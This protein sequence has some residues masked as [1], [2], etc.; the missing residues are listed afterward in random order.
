MKLHACHFSF[1]LTRTSSYLWM[2]VYPLSCSCKLLRDLSVVHVVDSEKIR[3][4][5]PFPPAVPGEQWSVPTKSAPRKG[6]RWN[7]NRVMHG[8]EHQKLDYR[9]TEE[10]ILVWHIIFFC[11]MWTAG[12]I[13]GA[14]LGKRW[15]QDAP[16]EEAMVTEAA[17]CSGQYS[18]EKPWV[19]RLCGCYF[20]MDRL[21]KHYTPSWWWCSPMAVSSLS[22]IIYPAPLQTVKERFEEQSVDSKYSRS[23]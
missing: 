7:C 3:W 5:Y 2:C 10:G 12:C 11:I 15:Y 16:Q 8:C 23:G 20:D 1:S 22:G 9:V 19:L 18:A 4:H 17:W 6:N 14:C 13:C 21:H